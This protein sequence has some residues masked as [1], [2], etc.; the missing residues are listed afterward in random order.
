MCIYGWRGVSTMLYVIKLQLLFC[1]IVEQK[2]SLTIFIWQGWDDPYVPRTHE[3]LLKWKYADM[4][5]VDFLFEVLLSPLLCFG[6]QC[7]SLAFCVSYK[8]KVS[9]SAVFFL[10]VSSCV[11]RWLVMIILSSFFM[12]G[13]RKNWWKE[14]KLNSKVCEFSSLSCYALFL[15]IIF[16]YLLHDGRLKH[17]L[18]GVLL[19]S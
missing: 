2:C 9:S 8:L 12:N 6:L 3:G 5:S 7:L 16:L 19:L 13:E 15:C 18:K 17:D 14:I 10:H 11:D 4:N 1:C